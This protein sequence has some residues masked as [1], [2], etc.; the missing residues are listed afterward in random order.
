MILVC[1]SNVNLQSVMHT[2][3]YQMGVSY[4]ASRVCRPLRR[5]V[6]VCGAHLGVGWRRLFA[7]PRCLADGGLDARQALVAA[8]CRATHRPR[9]SPLRHAVLQRTALCC[10][11]HPATP[12]SHRA[13]APTRRRLTRCEPTRCS[14]QAA[15][16]VRVASEAP[17]CSRP[18]RPARPS[19]RHHVGLP[20]PL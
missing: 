18:A 9:A 4:S 8:T 16:L 19:L 13:S 3:L 17:F 20:L 5:G 12:T 6:S 10:G 2:W 1:E 15:S 14:Q 11:A 7:R